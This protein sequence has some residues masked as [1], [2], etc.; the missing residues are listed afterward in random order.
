MELLTSQ[1]NGSFD[2]ISLGGGRIQDV[3]SMEKPNR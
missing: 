1:G 3:E 2:A